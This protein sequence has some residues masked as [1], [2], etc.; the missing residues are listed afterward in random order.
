MRSMMCVK[1]HRTILEAFGNDVLLRVWDSLVFDVRIRAAIGKVTRDLP[2]VVESHQPIIDALCRG[3]G[4][5]AGLAV[6]RYCFPCRS[7][8]GNF[9]SCP[10]S[11]SAIRHV[12]QI[13]CEVAL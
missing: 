6:G 2:E 13:L 11:S 1:L 12:G 5:E 9:H 10:K 4:R 7:L 8:L 3:Q